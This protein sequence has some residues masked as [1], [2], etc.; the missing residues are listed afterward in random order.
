MNVNRED[1]TINNDNGDLEAMKFQFN[2]QLQNFYSER[3]E[4]DVIKKP[5][6]ADRIKEVIEDIKSGKLAVSTEEIVSNWPDCKIVHGRPRHPESQGSVERSN[7]DVENMLRSWMT[8]YRAL[9]GSDPKVGLKSTNLPNSLIKELRTEE[10]LEDIMRSS[11][12][13]NSE[14][15]KQLGDEEMNNKIEYERQKSYSG[16]KRAAEKMTEASNKKFKALEIGSYVYLAV[17][18]VDRG[19][20]DSKN[21]TGKVFDSATKEET[22]GNDYNGRRSYTPRQK[23]NLNSLPCF[24]FELFHKIY[25]QSNFKTLQIANSLLLRF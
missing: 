9:F 4:K 22:I 16:Q 1:I 17:P 14:H 24:R 5:W 2:K 19:P 7:Q 23:G 6:T 12:T 25:A 11:Q 13:S 3:V 10:E 21:L 15:D 8:P 18:K 20:L